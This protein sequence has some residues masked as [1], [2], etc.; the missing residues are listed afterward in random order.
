MRRT[1]MVVAGGA[2]TAMLALSAGPVM[3]DEVEFSD[4]VDF[5]HNDHTVLL[6][7]WIE[8]FEYEDGELDIEFVDG[9][10]L[11]IEDTDLDS[12][13]DS[14][15]DFDGD[16]DGGSSNSVGFNSGGDSGGQNRSG[17]DNN[18]GGNNGGGNNGGRS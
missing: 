16:F 8:D 17:N 14:D 5:S 7:N 13:S 2:M 4:D 1:K 10:D 12:D 11:D 15:S 9:S 3:A 6:A 18:G